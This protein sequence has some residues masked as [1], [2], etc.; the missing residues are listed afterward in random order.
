MTD[1]TDLWTAV[2]DAYEDK[3]L[4]QLTN[5]RDRNAVAIA[6]SV[7]VIFWIRPP[8]KIICLGLLVYHIRVISSDWV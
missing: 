8:K 2:D 5:P 3:G 4:I 7:E 6:A 1:A